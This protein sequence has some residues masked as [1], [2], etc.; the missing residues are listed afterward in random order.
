[1][2]CSTS[3]HHVSYSFFLSSSFPQSL[4]LLPSIPTPNLPLRR[5]HGQADRLAHRLLG[6]KRSAEDVVALP[7]RRR[8]GSGWRGR[9]G[10]AGVARGIWLRDL[11]GR[12]REM[13]SGTS[14]F[15]LPTEGKDI[16]SKIARRAKHRIC[17]IRFITDTESIGVAHIKSVI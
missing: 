12:K 4:S 16:S 17:W 15:F 9:P 11:G 14:S 13:V 2:C 5:R 10:M 1:M 8:R 7:H 3:R 6:S